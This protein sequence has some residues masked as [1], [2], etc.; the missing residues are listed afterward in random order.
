MRNWPINTSGIIQIDIQSL[1]CSVTNKDIDHQ[2]TRNHHE[3]LHCF[4]RC[5]RLPGQPSD[6]F[7]RRD[8]PRAAILRSSSSPIILSPRGL[9]TSTS[10]GTCPDLLLPVSRPDDSLRTSFGHE[11]CAQRSPSSLRSLQRIRS[12]FI[13]WRIL[14]WT[15][16]HNTTSI[17]SSGWFLWSGD[18]EDRWCDWL[19]N[20]LNLKFNFH[21]FDL[22]FD[23]DFQV[24]L[25]DFML[26]IHIFFIY[27]IVRSAALIGN[28]SGSGCSY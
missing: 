22:F 15:M 20:K 4:H 2:P 19:D 5:R 16:D 6:C 25:Q 3:V 23:R 12:S 9:R 28:N 24:L 1:L 7:T 10:D 8:H 11:L 13:R 17:P 21:W 14:N 18:L 26:F 27:L